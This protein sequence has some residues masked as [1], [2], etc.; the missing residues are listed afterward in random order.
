MV[1]GALF[2]TLSLIASVASG[3]ISFAP[4]V[5]IRGDL[6]YLGQVIDASV[7]PIELRDRAAKLPLIKLPKG[8]TALTL[9][10]SDIESR[11]RSIMPALAPMFKNTNGT[12][13]VLRRKEDP[14]RLVASATKENGINK[15]DR[16]RVKI[17]AGIYTIERQGIA[18][19][20][21]KAGERLFVKTE[22]RK[23]LSVICCGE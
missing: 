7:L 15:G 22:D 3:V 18:L 20:D 23:A 13:L 4:E 12:V 19:S 11:A 2:S 21:A 14:M 6:L 8:T 5:V 9:R 16:T 1:V 17:V 10:T